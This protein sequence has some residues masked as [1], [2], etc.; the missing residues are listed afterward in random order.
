M[1]LTL[2]AREDAAEILNLYHSVLDTPGSRWDMD[3]PAPEN[4]EDDLARNALF[5][6]KEGGEI[7]AAISID[8]DEAVE[9]L[10][11]WNPAL[12]PAMEL[13]RLCVRTDRQGRGLASRMIEAMM[14]YGKDRGMKAVRYLVSKDNPIAQKAYRRL[15]FRRAGECSLYG[16]EFLCYEKEL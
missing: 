1:N 15:D 14:D 4:V 11:F 16:E 2:A 8:R 9:A 3:Y 6:L 5:C 7:I 12:Q 10:P 13:S